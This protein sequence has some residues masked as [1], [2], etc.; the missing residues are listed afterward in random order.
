MPVFCR[1]QG[2]FP[3]AIFFASTSLFLMSE[4]GF[5]PFLHCDPETTVLFQGIKNTNCDG[6]YV[7]EFP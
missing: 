4:E 7:S 5:V 3:A 2:L 1:S 6:R